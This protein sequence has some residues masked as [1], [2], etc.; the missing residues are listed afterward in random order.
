MCLSLTLAQVWSKPVE[1]SDETQPATSSSLSE[2]KLQTA[3]LQAW[4]SDF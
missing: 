1:R 2:E 4:Q 3:Y